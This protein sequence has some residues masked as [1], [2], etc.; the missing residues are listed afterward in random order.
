MPRSSPF[1]PS[2]PSPPLPSQAATR[3]RFFII[4]L[5]V[6]S[7]EISVFGE[8]GGGKGDAKA[9]LL[10]VSFSQPALRLLE[11]EPQKAKNGMLSVTHNT[12]ASK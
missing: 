5:H 12:L 11:K 4:M 6:R 8:G 3:L 9:L 7:I 10:H 2:V 1:L